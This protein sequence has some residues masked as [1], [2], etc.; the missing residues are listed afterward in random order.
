[1]T[2][3]WDR[4]TGRNARPTEVRLKVMTSSHIFKKVKTF[5]FKVAF[6][7]AMFKAMCVEKESVLYRLYVLYLLDF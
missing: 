1:M 4:V 7:K 6:C 2:P 5:H 3:A